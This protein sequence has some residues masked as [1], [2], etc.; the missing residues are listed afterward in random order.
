MVSGSSSAK[1]SDDREHRPLHGF[2]RLGTFHEA[3]E[4]D[5]SIG[6]PGELA[7]RLARVAAESVKAPYDNR[8][9]RANVLE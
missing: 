8:V 2:G 1:S 7:Q 3:P 6:E 4:A 9:A 5:A